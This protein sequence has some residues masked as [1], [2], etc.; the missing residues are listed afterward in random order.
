ML[1]FLSFH[2]IMLSLLL[3]RFYQNSYF[4]LE[5]K[6]IPNTHQPVS[7]YVEERKRIKKIKSI[8]N[9]KWNGESAAAHR[10]YRILLSIAI[11][12][13]DCQ[14]FSLSKTCMVTLLYFTFAKLGLCKY[15]CPMM[16]A[17]KTIYIY[18]Q[19]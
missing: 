1:L 7:K 17:C 13:S 4:L 5:S 6:S 12:F 19:I 10:K 3:I 9:I 11:L 15:L 8:L 18:L 16:I 14:I 2:S